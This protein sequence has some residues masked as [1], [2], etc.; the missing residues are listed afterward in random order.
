MTEMF[1]T[2]KR[3]DE[4]I[5]NFHETAKELMLPNINIEDEQ[6]KVILISIID[7]LVEIIPSYLAIVKEA[8]IEQLKKG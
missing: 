4:I 1:L 2:S 5:N 7:K 3:L 8:K 6:L